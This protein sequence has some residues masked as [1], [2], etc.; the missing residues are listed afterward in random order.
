MDSASRWVGRSL[1]VGAAALASACSDVTPV[2]PTS[3]T[4]ARNGAAVADISSGNR[5]P[6]LASCPQL[7]APEGSTLLFHGFGIGVQIYHWN[8]TSWGTATPSATI[9]ADAGG[10]GK[11]A[12]HFAGPSWQTASGSKVVGTVA[13][14]CTP[15]PASIA[16]L[17]LS[18]VAEGDGLFAT[19]N[20]IQRL[21]T[22]GG[23]APS[24][25]GT[26]IGQE[27]QIPYSA[28]YLFYRA[29]TE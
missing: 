22:V 23:N 16:W 27:A 29:P 26:V 3:A 15:D 2:A 24:T 6:D 12:D 8:G 4:T 11:V 9:Y 10:Q 28:D 25:P 21:N 19:V 20:F 18:A 5:L 17:A 7:A 14:R 13:N 1:L